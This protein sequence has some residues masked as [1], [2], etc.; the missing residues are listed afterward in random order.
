MK[1]VILS[2]ALA[3]AAINTNAQE[4]KFGA[5]AG[6][7]ANSIGRVGEAYDG[8]DSGAKFDLGFHFGAVA[9]FA[10]SEKLSFRP[11]ISFSQRGATRKEGDE[12]TETNLNYIVT[13]FNAAYKFGSFE[14]T[15]G[16]YVALLTGGKV[17]QGN[18]EYKVKPS[19]S[20]VSAEDLGGDIGFNGLDLGLN[21]GAGYHIAENMLISYQFSFGLSNLQP[22][23]DGVSND[24]RKDLKR[25]N[26]TNNI[27]FTYFFN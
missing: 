20:E 13:D 14:A 1:K 11:G 15:A 4:I 18:E 23:G 3:F 25:S 16:P 5:K 6:L 2:V 12:K 8:E 24:A 27:S 17:K 7:N 21:I 22:K 19:F 10:F 9:D 26:A